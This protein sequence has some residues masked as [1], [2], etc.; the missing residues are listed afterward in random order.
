MKKIL[1]TPGMILLFV[2]IVF[3]SEFLGF[4]S[5]YLWVFA[6]AVGVLAGV[7][8]VM[9]L[10]KKWQHFGVYA[11]TTLVWIV[12]MA[13]AGEVSGTSVILFMIFVSLTAE[14]VRYLIGYQSK[15]GVLMSYAVFGLFPAAS[16]IKLWIDP[17]FYYAGAIEELNSVEY[18][19]KL[20]TFNNPV[21]FFAFIAVTFVAGLCGVVLAEKI[22]KDKV[23]LE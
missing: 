21:G 14:L 10:A 23:T 11:L 8:P 12:I 1:F 9:A 22:F 2:L 13:L 5:P 4:I 18:A 20:M 19:D 16:L 7:G 6:G 15:N 17:D 3:A